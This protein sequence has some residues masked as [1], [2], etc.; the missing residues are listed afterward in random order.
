MLVPAMSIHG[1]VLWYLNA[2]AYDHS[3]TSVEYQSACD[4]RRLIAEAY[5]QVEDKHS[6]LFTTWE[7]FFAAEA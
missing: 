3:L 7:F 2:L 6:M 4:A 5:D 1:S